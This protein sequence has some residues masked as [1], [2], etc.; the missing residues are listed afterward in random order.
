MDSLRAAA[1]EMVEAATKQLA[2]N[3]RRLTGVRVTARLPASFNFMHVHQHPSA[4]NR[5]N[6]F[7][8][9]EFLFERLPVRC[10]LRAGSAPEDPYLQEQLQMAA[11]LEAAMEQLRQRGS[12]K[13]WHCHLD[14]KSF[15][16]AEAFRT[17]I[18]VRGCAFRGS[19]RPGLNG[20]AQL[21]S[22]SH[23]V[24]QALHLKQ[25][26]C[27]VAAARGSHNLPKAQDRCPDAS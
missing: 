9:Q 7:A 1:K 21:R 10:D 14:S 25:P 26:T 12:W 27:S 24:L 15:Y 13:A 22:A 5:L 23:N 19:R 17:H 4:L 16:D 6:R 3:A 20:C 2:D 11:G 18:V 8:E